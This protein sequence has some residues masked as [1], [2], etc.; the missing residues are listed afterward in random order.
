LGTDSA[1]FF[2]AGVVA[3]SI[4]L[5]GGSGADTLVFGGGAGAGG[6]NGGL[7]GSIMGGAGNDS[8]TITGS[9]TGGIINL[10]TG[11]DTVSFAGLVSGSSII[12]GA[13]NDSVNFASI[14]QGSTGLTNGNTYY[15]GT[16]G[17]AD[18]LQFNGLSGT[19]AGKAL[20]IAASDGFG[21]TAGTIIYSNETSTASI[22]FGSGA[23]QGSIYVTGISQGAVALNGGSS[24]MVNVAIVSNATI[25]AFG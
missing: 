18:T 10:G 24:G 25:T 23:N 20:T 7:T 14:L 22:T 1:N 11:S 13:G 5:V 19:Q 16:N 12:G 9:S 2:S 3:T 8:L 17:G 15:F 6:F 21:V 4:T